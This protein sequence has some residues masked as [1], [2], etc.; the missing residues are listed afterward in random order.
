MILMI[1]AE[2]ID[3]KVLNGKIGE[4][5]GVAAPINSIHV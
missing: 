2:K 4:N 3:R 5:P 1:L